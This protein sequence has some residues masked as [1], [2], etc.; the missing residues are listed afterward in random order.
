MP[1]DIQTRVI[2]V[3]ADYTSA[4]VPVPM[5]EHFLVFDLGMD[6]LEMIAAITSL[7]NEFGLRISDD[8]MAEVSTVGELSRFIESRLSAK[9]N[10]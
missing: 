1:S 2:S 6:S 4:R 8:I 3:L 5:P 7:E 9:V 10:V